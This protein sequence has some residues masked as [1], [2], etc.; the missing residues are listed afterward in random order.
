MGEKAKAVLAH[1]RKMRG[2]LLPDGEVTTY[3]AGETESFLYVDPSPPYLANPTPKHFRRKVR[4][5]WVI[6]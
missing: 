5:L 2:M 6:K 3:D 4:H 1:L